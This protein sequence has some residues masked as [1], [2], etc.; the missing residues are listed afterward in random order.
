[1]MRFP[2]ALA[3]LLALAPADAGERGLTAAMMRDALARA[4]VNT[5][6][7]S[8]MMMLEG[9]QWISFRLD[10]FSIRVHGG[11]FTID[12]DTTRLD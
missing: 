9:R 12:G 10:A 4:H 5:A 2:A 1:M 3:I 11:H 8:V 7:G 6:P